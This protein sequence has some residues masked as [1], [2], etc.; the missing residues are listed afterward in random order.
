VLGSTGA[1]HGY[2]WGLDRKRAMLAVEAAR[3]EAA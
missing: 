3:A 1:L 2:H